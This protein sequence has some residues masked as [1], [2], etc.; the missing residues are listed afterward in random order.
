[1]G[2]L[3][4]QLAKIF[5]LRPS[6]APTT[7]APAA[8]A[9]ATGAK[10]PPYSELG[11]LASYKKFCGEM[12]GKDFADPRGTLVSLLEANFPKLLG[13]KLKTSGK[14]TKASVLIAALQNGKL[15]ESLYTV[16]KDRIRTLF[17][18]EDT[19]CRCDSIHPNN[20]PV[21]AADEVYVKRYAKLGANVKLVFTRREQAG[22]VIVVTHFLAD[23]KDLPRFV[24]TPPLW[25][26][27]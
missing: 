23:L 18:I 13:A 10:H 14:K 5:G 7:P 20:H 1:M 21:I 8:P 9:A 19:I 24:K 17:W 12:A 16:E 22:Q 3:K 25:L 6:P 11:I 15:D 27:K 2:S 26:K 4:E